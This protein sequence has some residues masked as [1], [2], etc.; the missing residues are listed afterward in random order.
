MPNM[1]EAIMIFGTVW[2]EQEVHNVTR[3]VDLRISLKL[4]RSMTMPTSLPVSALLRR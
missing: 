3:Q 1:A 2:R 4:T